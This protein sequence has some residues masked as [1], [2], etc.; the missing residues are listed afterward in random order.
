MRSTWAELAPDPLDLT[1]KVALITGGGTGI[2][3]ESARVLARHGADVVLTS[4]H[5]EDLTRTGDDIAA[6]TGRRY[7]AVTGDVKIEDDIKS[8]VRDSIDHFGRIDILVNNAGGSRPSPALTLPTKAWD[9]VVDLNLKAPF[10]LSREVAA[11][12]IDQGGGSIV[13]ISSLGGV[14]GGKGLAHYSAAKAGLQM[15]TR[16]LAAEWAGYGIRVN[17]VAVGTVAS[18]RAVAV[19]EETGNHIDSFTADVP[20]GRIGVP[21]DIAHPVLFLAANLSA[22]VTGQT[23]SSSGG[24]PQLPGVPDELLAQMV[25]QARAGPSC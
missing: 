24:Y 7:L 12:M 13:N 15:L 3:A 20:L 2:G 8:V 11:H 21:L 6:A 19:W 16:V 1:G 10:L 17:C 9:A 18:E 14:N 23:F 4:R 25:E 22:F 5:L